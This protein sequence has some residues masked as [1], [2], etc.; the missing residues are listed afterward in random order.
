MPLLIDPTI[1]TWVLLPL[2][3]L[4]VLLHFLRGAV[5]KLTAADIRPELTELRQKSI[6]TRS[7]RLRA[8]GGYISHGGFAARRAWLLEPTSGELVNA[9][10]V[11]KPPNPMA[12]P[13][14]MK[15]QVLSMVRGDA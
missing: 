3:V 6:I 13:D 15:G 10:V 5:M 11:D 8:H 4:V 1:G 9:A 7:Q 12:S 2:L 14:M